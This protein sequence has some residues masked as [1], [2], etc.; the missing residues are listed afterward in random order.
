MIITVESDIFVSPATVWVHPVNTAGVMGSGLSSEFKRFFPQVYEEYR[1]LCASGRLALGRV[2][3]AQAGRKRILHLPIKAHW[4]A[5][6]K[7]EDIEAAVQLLASRWAEWG[8]GSLAVP[9]F[10]DGDLTWQADIRPLFESALDALP[11][12]V[13]LHIYD[14]KHD[15]ARNLRQIADL[16]NKP[17]GRVPFERLLRDLGRVIRKAN[18]RFVVGGSGAG[19]SVSLEATARR[20]RLTLTPDDGEPQTLSDSQLADLWATLQ[21]AGLLMGWQFPGALEP[22]ALYLIPLLDG[23]D[24]VRGV[25]AAVSGSGA[26]PNALLFV[27]PLTQASPHT[28]TLTATEE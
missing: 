15:A 18:G 3:L 5:N 7:R 9:E 4:R 19:F 6:A 14:R 11:I 12:P 13:Y 16:L 22:W 10:G 20:T 23:L 24:Y 2:W 27:P 1:A 25:T 28:L 21:A 26:A 8:I 17:V